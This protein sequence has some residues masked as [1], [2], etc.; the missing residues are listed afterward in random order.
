MGIEAVGTGLKGI[1]DDISGLRVF[2]TN[3]LPDS[4]NDLPCA[5]ILPGE[6]IYDTTFGEDYD[7]KL[8]ILIL[9][10]KQDSPSAFDKIIPYIEP[11]GTSSI[12][13]KIQADLTLGGNCDT[14]KVIRNLGIGAT[15]W[16]GITYLSTEFEIVVY[17]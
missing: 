14:C 6:T 11:T 2:A 13:A 5:L 15:N 9:L 17:L 10:A 4:I 3:E 7:M 12:L 16:G 8:R 1:L